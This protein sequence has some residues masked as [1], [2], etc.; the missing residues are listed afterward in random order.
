MTTN[1]NNVVDFKS[2]NYTTEKGPLVVMLTSGPEDGGKRA[3]LAYCAACTALGMDT[4]TMIFLVGDGAHWGY[5][6]HAES[7]HMNG[8][9]P[10]SE[11]IEMFR[12]LGGKTYICSTCDQVC[13]IPG[14]AEHTARVRRPD[15]LP[16][17]LAA[18]LSEISC[19]S[20]VTF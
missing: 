2:V 15:V 12:E 17:G 20:S 11:L 1:N 4:E 13:G 9:P 6:G 3:T 19:G 18:I 7:Y 5:E 16:S 10:L 8:F 14:E